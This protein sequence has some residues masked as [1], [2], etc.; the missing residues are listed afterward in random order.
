MQIEDRA[1]HVS[2]TIDPAG[3]AQLGAVPAAADFFWE[4]WI[5]ETTGSE[6]A[7]CYGD[8]VRYCIRIHGVGSFT[9]TRHSGLVVGTPEVGVA[10]DLVYEVFCR[11]VV[12]FVLQSHS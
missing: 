11:R 9:F 12:P 1:F 5:D 3:T 2:L 4:P 8:T 6:W 7:C 10:P